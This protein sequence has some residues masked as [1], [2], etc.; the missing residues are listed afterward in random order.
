MAL[1][2]GVFFSHGAEAKAPRYTSV[3]TIVSTLGYFRV[4][5]GCKRVI[6][7]WSV[8]Y[9]ASFYQCEHVIPPNTGKELGAG[10]RASTEVVL[11]RVNFGSS[12][13]MKGIC[14][15]GDKS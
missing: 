5:L 14:L 6:H 2:C 9:M 3:R 7:I 8:Q 15:A 12:L 4:T 11:L 13:P 1:H 10:V